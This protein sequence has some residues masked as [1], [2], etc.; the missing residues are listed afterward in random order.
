[1]YTCE[2]SDIYPIEENDKW[3]SS[4]DRWAVQFTFLIR[5]VRRNA[6]WWQKKK[7]LIG[8]EIYGLACSQAYAANPDRK[9][10]DS[11][12]G[13]LV[14]DKFSEDELR[15]RLNESLANIEA[16]SVQGL[17]D[18]IEKQFIVEEVPN[19]EQA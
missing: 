14:F 9:F 8:D 18:Q 16:Q 6:H 12:K 19:F 3:K 7:L 2:L 17:F 5:A 15:S 10:Y 4:D 13:I 1:M 11:S